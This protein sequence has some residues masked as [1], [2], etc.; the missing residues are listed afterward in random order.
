[1]TAESFAPKSDFLRILTERGYIHQASDLAGI[2]AAALEG[3]LTTYVGYDCTAPSLH[4]GHLLSIMMLH[5]LQATGGRP[6]ALM[7]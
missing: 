7:G 1:M 2:D 6:I 5:W 4:V 3:R